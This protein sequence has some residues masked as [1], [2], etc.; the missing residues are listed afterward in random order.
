MEGI[1]HT[2]GTANAVNLI[3]MKEIVS[4]TIHDPKIAD[5]PFASGVSTI[6]PKRG[7]LYTTFEVNGDEKGESTSFDKNHKALVHLPL[8][9]AEEGKVHFV[10]CKIKRRRR[11]LRFLG[12]K[13]L[14]TAK[15]CLVNATKGKEHVSGTI[16]DRKGNDI[17]S[18]I[19]LKAEIFVSEWNRDNLGTKTDPTK[20]PDLYF[21]ILGLL[22]NFQMKDT[23]LGDTSILE[24][25][26]MYADKNL[27]R[28]REFDGLLEYP[29]TDEFLGK[30]WKG[31]LGLKVMNSLLRATDCTVP[32]TYR[33]AAINNVRLALTCG[34]K[35]PFEDRWIRPLS[36]ESIQRV[37]FSSLGME[38]VQKNSENGGYVV[39]LTSLGKLEYKNNMENLG[40]KVYF[41]TN[42]RV[43]EIENHED[44]VVHRPRTETWEWAKLKARSNI[45]ITA[46]LRHLMAYHF[47][48]GCAPGQALRMFLPPTHP[49]RMAFSVH[50]CRTHWTCS[51]AK[52][53]LLDE[54][55]VLGRALPFAYIDGYE[56]ILRDQLEAYRFQTYPDQLESQGVTDCSFHVGS[57]DGLAMHEIM[58]NYAHNIFDEVYVTEDRFSQDETMR[59]LYAYLRER[60]KGLP[61]EYSMAN[62][63][64]LWGEI[65]F[66]VTGGHN[67]IGNAAAYALAPF[68]I[69]L[70]MQKKDKGILKSSM[71]S[72]TTVAGI[73]KATIPDDFPRL[74]Q[75]WSHVL[76]DPKSTAYATLTSELERL[77][78]SID[79]RNDSEERR[80]TN[81]DFHPNFCGI[82]V[83]G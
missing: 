32:V 42:G 17:G 58:V 8:R 76:D 74:Y 69:N 11:I 35:S 29:T 1:E 62:V 79:E 13:T 37:F 44:R 77:G 65:L 83:F 80:F 2:N 3:T 9:A 51:Q 23:N 38:F 82:S 34:V 61:A 49:I 40:C 36:D 7:K 81:R 5:P 63:K 41:D 39:D 52:E 68:M 16:C 14:F 18:R 15:L 31:K 22:I 10:A 20:N 75:G 28:E 46:S 27:R 70:R 4:V 64:M 21:R 30:P 59:E 19:V 66:R 45:F 57:T 72:D 71:E 48:W 53:Q 60:M 24:K 33:S 56:R 6:L 55:G 50:F 67:S 26:E 78:E 73:T 47:I 12:D 25:P 43:T 54:F